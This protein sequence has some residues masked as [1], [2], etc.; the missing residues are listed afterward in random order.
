MKKSF[1]KS[2][3]ALAVA[4][5]STVAF[6]QDAVTGDKVAALSRPVPAGMKSEAEIKEWVRDMI[7]LT[8]VH[9]TKIEEQIAAAM[10]SINADEAA[11]DAA[12][13]I[14]GERADA[15]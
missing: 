13:T 6:A 12:I 7:G 15:E 8:I 1:K 4:M 10:E 2:I 11:M 3:F 9:G 14:D 5:V